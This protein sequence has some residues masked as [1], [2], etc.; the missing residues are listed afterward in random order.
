MDIEKCEALLTVL[1]L[2]NLSAAASA[3]G[4]TPS[5]ISRMMQSLEEDAGF[6]L[7]TRGRNGVAPTPE[8]LQLLPAIR[9][10]VRT[11]RLLEE[12]RRRCGGRKRERSGSDV[13][14]PTIMD[15]LQRRSHPSQNSI[16]GSKWRSFRA[17]APGSARL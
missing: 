3:L 1:E 10:M 2:G 13:H 9:D 12:R 11:G 5:G 7:L 8:C 17:T 14:I 15:G 6:P 16:P 4:Y